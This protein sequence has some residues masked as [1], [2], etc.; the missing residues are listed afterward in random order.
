MIVMDS[1]IK[2][3][4]FFFI[5][6]I[7]VFLVSMGL[8][9]IIIYVLRIMR[10]IGEI[11]RLVRYEAEHISSDIGALRSR[12]QDKGALVSMFLSHIR[13]FFSG[14]STGKGRRVKVKKV[15]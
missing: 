4:V 8:L 15:K 7:A 12:M 11:V 6:T 2:A 10:D 14:G 3:D 9:G 13:G 1:F 5:T